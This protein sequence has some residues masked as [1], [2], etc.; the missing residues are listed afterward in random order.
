[1]GIQT[2][3][4]NRLIIMLTLFSLSDALTLIIHHQLLV[5]QHQIL[6]Y[7]GVPGFNGP[8]IDPSALYIQSCVCS[9]L[10]SAFYLRSRIGDKQHISM[11]IGNEKKLA[12]QPVLPIPLP[13]TYDYSGQQQVQYSGQYVQGGY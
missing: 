4:F 8:T 7:A 3:T 2:G 12:A 1:M 13:P 5:Q 11:L 6:T 9:F 10:H